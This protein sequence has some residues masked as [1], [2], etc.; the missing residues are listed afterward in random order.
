MYESYFGY[1]ALG[2]DTAA[3]YSAFLVWDS[4]PQAIGYDKTK[5]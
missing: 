3:H 4:N 5:S 2:T 1:L